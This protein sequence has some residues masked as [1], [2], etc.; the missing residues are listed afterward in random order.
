MSAFRETRNTSK[1]DE[2]TKIGD[3]NPPNKPG[4]GEKV[5]KQTQETKEETKDAEGRN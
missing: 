4:Q 3:N 1:D 5:G 2:E